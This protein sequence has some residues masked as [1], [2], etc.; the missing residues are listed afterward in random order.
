MDYL[1]KIDKNYYYPIRLS[2]CIFFLLFFL[3]FGFH[4]GIG[5]TS[6]IGIMF[7]LLMT[8]L[9]TTKDMWKF[10]NIMYNMLPNIALILIIYN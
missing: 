7:F 9:Y 5:Y 3:L 8:I 4:N 10:A 1:N 6:G 2:I